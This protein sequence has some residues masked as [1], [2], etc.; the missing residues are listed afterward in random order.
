MVGAEEMFGKCY[1]FRTDDWIAASF[2]VQRYILRL[3]DTSCEKAEGEIYCA[4]STIVI[5]HS[6]RCELCVVP[7]ALN[8]HQTRPTTRREE[9]VES[10]QPEEGREN[11]RKLAEAE[12]EEEIGIFFTTLR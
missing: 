9:E 6:R 7:E 10:T 12:N 4:S 1:I 8:S 2:Q 11:G 5:H 3:T